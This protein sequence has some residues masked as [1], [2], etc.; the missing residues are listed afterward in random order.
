MS[1]SKVNPNIWNGEE[2]SGGYLAK[3]ASPT[4]ANSPDY[5]GRLYLSGVGWF[6][7][8][9]WNKNKG[10]GDVLAL[11]VQEMTDEQATKFCQPKPQ[12]HPKT[13]ETELNRGARTAPNGH[14]N[15]DTDIP[16]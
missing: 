14:G 7:I 2:R 11:R 9:A 12:R 4:S 10:N 16:F 1:A 8:S 3:N 5:K 13:G 6:W 15:S